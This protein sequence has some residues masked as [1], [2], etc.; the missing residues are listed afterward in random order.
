[1]TVCKLNLVYNKRMK[2][3][4]NEIFW[5]NPPFSPSK[6]FQNPK[7]NRGVNWLIKEV[8]SEYIFM[9]SLNCLFEPFRIRCWHANCVRIFSF[10]I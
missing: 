7:K 9:T 10:K 5:G 6:K 8:E 2:Q 4:K 1:M 3:K